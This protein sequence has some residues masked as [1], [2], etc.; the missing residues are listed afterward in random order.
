MIRAG[1]GPTDA[2]GAVLRVRACSCAHEFE[3]NLHFW[4]WSKRMPS[5]ASDL[6]GAHANPWTAACRQTADR[7]VLL[8]DVMVRRWRGSD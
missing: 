4:P 1:C 2:H 6:H 7:R 8:F 5:F 3:A